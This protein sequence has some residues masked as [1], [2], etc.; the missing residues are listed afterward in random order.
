ME[1]R[2]IIFLAAIIL[3]IIIMLQNT[4]IVTVTLLFWKINLS[5][6]VLIVIALLVGFVM[7]YLVNSLKASKG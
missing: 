6:I 5:K 1:A 2:K 4:Q 7:G 3:A